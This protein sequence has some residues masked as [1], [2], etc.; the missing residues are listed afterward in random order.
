MAN[1]A[2]FAVI[3]SSR[4]QKEIAQAW[5]W[6]E[7]RQQ[8]LGDRFVK[9]ITTVFGKIETNPLRFP[10]RYKTYHEAVVSV[11]PYLIVYKVLKRQKTIQIVSIFHTSLDPKKKLKSGSRT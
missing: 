5:N 3:I 10:K 1:S 6:Y 11:F 4:A 7:D 9:E 2:A 8:G